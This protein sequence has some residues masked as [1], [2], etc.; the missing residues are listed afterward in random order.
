MGVSNSNN[1]KNNKD[2]TEINIIYNIKDQKY[3]RLFGDTFV[4]KYKNFC[5]MIINNKKYKIET[6]YNVKNYK[7]IN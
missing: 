4:K 1:K 3:I 6:G 5:K 7:K 2:I